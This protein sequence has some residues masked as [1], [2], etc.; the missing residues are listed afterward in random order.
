MS[1]TLSAAGLA[2]CVA[3]L[4]WPAGSAGAIRWHRCAQGHPTNVQCGELSV[5]LDYAKPEGAKIRLGFNRLRAA[6]RSHRIGSLILNPGGPGGAGSEVVEAEAA[7]LHLWDAE[8]HLRFD[9]IGMDPRGIGTSTPIRC[10][11]A[12]IN[13]PVSLFPNTPEQFAQLEAYSRAVGD[14]CLR[15]TGPLL[16]HVD[17]K[18]VAR[19][20]EAL[21]HALGEGKLNFLGLSYGAALG[22]QYAELYPKRIRVMALDGALEHAITAQRLFVDSTI[23]YEDTFNRFVAWCART[24]SCP[25]HGRDVAALFDALVA[26]ADRDPIAAPECAER[27]CRPTVTGGDL[28]LNSEEGLLTKEGIKAFE[29]PGW[30]DSA[31]LLAGVEQGSAAPFSTGLARAPDDGSLAGLAVLC[32]DYPFAVTSYDE[33]ARDA[34]LARA[35]APHTQGASEA[36]GPL[37]G[38]AHWPV[39]VSNPPHRLR[40]RGAPRILL[41]NA[42]HDPSTPYV[43]AQG[44]ASQLPSAVLITRAG[45]GHTSSWLKRPSRTRD[46]ITR[47]LI[48]RRAPPRGT[49]YPD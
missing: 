6:D 29:L 30:N 26:R 17:T 47:Y 41:A 3:A 24:T 31:R 4:C 28:R 15:L 22:A 12:V 20:M 23:A 7:G 37:T 44:L 36:W 34:A 16:G 13:Q 32:V 38:C 11:P 33:F 48:T 8:L 46:A 10:D 21:R 45:D 49:V 40:V 1:R 39:P 5:P 14:S 2:V 27:G 9:L 42:T 19:D 25:L 43:W 18:S 35:L